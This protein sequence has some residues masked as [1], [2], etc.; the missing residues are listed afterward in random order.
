VPGGL[1]CVPGGLGCGGLGAPFISPSSTNVGADPARSMSPCTR[2]AF[3]MLLYVD[4]SHTG[5]GIGRLLLDVARRERPGGPRLWTFASNNR[6]QRFYE[7]YGFVDVRRTD[8]AANEERAP[9]IESGGPSVSDGAS[10]TRSTCG[11]TAG[12]RGSSS[13]CGTART[14]SAAGCSSGTWCIWPPCPGQ[15]GPRCKSS[16]SGRVDFSPRRTRTSGGLSTPSPP[17]VPS[18]RWQMTSTA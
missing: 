6:A 9:D 2:A 15:I 8:G 18:K 17:P 1:G 3:V 5:R 12:S 13:R 16:G 10:R 14:R 4:P 11:R 7:Q